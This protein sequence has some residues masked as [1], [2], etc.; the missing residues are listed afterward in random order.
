[1]A[2]GLS[3]FTLIASLVSY[4]FLHIGWRPFVLAPRQSDNVTV[5]LVLL[6][7]TMALI[8][9]IGTG[10]GAALSSF[11]VSRLTQLAAA[12][13]SGTVSA[14]MLLQPAKRLYRAEFERLRSR[15]IR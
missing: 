6:P 8:A 9:A 10:V 5:L 2:F 7:V 14:L 13:S 3:A 12:L 1:M 15:Q 11:G 4:L